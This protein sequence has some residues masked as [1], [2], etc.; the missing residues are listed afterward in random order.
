MLQTAPL[1]FWK[2][3][4]TAFEFIL[5]FSGVQNSNFLAK[6]ERSQALR[7][8]ER[9]MESFQLRGFSLL[10]SKQVGGRTFKTRGYNNLLDSEFVSS[11][12]V[13]EDAKVISRVGEIVVKVF[14]KKDAREISG[15]GINT[16]G[17]QH[18]HF[19]HEKA[20]KGDVKSHGVS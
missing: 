11:A 2:F 12:K 1:L 20:L 14:R 3:T 8:E 15:R 10:R 4:W 18:H 16:Y 19:V 5:P 7:G 13:S 17:L 9:A 6:T